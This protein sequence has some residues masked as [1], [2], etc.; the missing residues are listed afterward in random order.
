MV[1]CI[2]NAVC[3]LQVA[4]STYSTTRSTLQLQVFVILFS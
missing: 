1:A 2:K 4:S 3:S